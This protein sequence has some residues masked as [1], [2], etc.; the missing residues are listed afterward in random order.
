MRLKIKV[1]VSRARSGTESCM[2]FFGVLLQIPI[3]C[4]FQDWRDFWI[5]SR[6]PVPKKILNSIIVT[7]SRN[8]KFPRSICVYIFIT[9]Y[10]IIISIKAHCQQINYKIKGTTS[11]Q[12]YC[13]KNKFRCKNFVKH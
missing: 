10:F 4:N 2:G 11:K 12:F 8:A 13:I 9:I 3:F 1:F 6:N 7:G 5:Q